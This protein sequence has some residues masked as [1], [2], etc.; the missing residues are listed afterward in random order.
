M[1]RAARRHASTEES[2]VGSICMLAGSVES[3]PGGLTARA[4]DDDTGGVASCSLLRGVRLSDQG[5]KERADDEE[6]EEDA[7]CRRGKESERER[8]ER[9]HVTCDRRHETKLDHDRKEYT[10]ADR[11]HA[12][13]NHDPRKQAGE[14][15]IAHVLQERDGKRG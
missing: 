8:S 5:A 7:A 10:V 4:C 1:S 13:A 14:A 11:V 2:R 12:R 9:E 6:R 3:T 15:D